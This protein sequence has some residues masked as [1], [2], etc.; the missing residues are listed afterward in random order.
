MRTSTKDLRIPGLS[1]AQ[2]WRHGGSSS[3]WVARR[4]SDSQPVAIKVLNVRPDDSELAN[5][6]VSSIAQLGD[7]DGVITA[8]GFGEL[9]SGQRYITMPFVGQSL[10]DLKEPL[11]WLIG[12]RLMRSVARTTEFAHACGVL[13]RDIKPS[14]IL[15]DDGSPRLAD[16]GIAKLSYDTVHTYTNAPTSAGF[17][18]PE[19]LRHKSGTV[20]SDVYS[21]GATLAVLLVGPDHGGD[22]VSAVETVVND[23]DLPSGLR[24]LVSAATALDPRDRTP[25]A[26]HFANELESLLDVSGEDVVIDLRNLVEER[27]IPSLPERPRENARRFRVRRLAFPLLLTLLAIGAL[28]WVRS[29][30]ETIEYLVLEDPFLCDTELRVAGAVSGL[31][32]GGPIHILSPAASLDVERQADETGRYE[33][34]WICDGAASQAWPVQVRDLTT[35]S[36]I[37]FAISPRLSGL[38]RYGLEPFTAPDGWVSVM[39]QQDLLE[40]V[41]PGGKIRN[42][43]TPGADSVM[44]APASDGALEYEIAVPADLS[45]VPWPWNKPVLPP[46]HA[47]VV[48]E[49]TRGP[50]E[51]R[52]CGIMFG[53]AAPEGLVLDI[54]NET[55]EGAFV[56]KASGLNA[57]LTRIVAPGDEEPVNHPALASYPSVLGAE[58]RVRIDVLVDSGGWRVAV[59]GVIIARGAERLSNTIAVPT[60]QHENQ[61]QAAEVGC[62]FRDWSIRVPA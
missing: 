61:W 39:D 21:L 52:A 3:V 38:D 24:E 34:N 40:M 15:L 9:A 16:W 7:H 59:D 23:T 46:F 1:E 41:V 47:S 50:L 12:V 8:T 43:Q 20:A 54:D 32:P 37:E 30:S 48:V 17:A 22:V 45:V 26:R 33:I 25:S 53:L 55:A 13:H 36:N 62:R 19:R 31:T 49:S 4:E 58:D 44:L 60:M 35:S 11:P 56:A 2:L 14:N 5:R 6:E 51:W 29:S 57:A 18:A 28:F 10:A 42:E 27:P